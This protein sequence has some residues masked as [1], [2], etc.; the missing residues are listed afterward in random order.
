MERIDTYAGT[1]E[2]MNGSTTL[3][4]VRYS[5]TCHQRTAVN[6]LPVPGAFRIHGTVDGGMDASFADLVGLPLGL[7]LADG[8]VL[9]VMLSDATGT[10]HSEGH[11]PA[12]CQCC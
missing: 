9:G 12:K 8:R 10:I 4:P 11:G 6:G 7:K 5:V 2:L 3:R 1:G